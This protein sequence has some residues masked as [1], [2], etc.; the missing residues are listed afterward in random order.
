M[1]DKDLSRVMLVSIHDD[2]V[3][4]LTIVSLLVMHPKYIKALKR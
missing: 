4:K 1:M 2:Y 3:L